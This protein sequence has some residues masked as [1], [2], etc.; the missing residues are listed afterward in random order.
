MNKH[1]VADFLRV[2]TKTVERYVKSG[3]LRTVYVG[4]KAV[5][6]K[7]EVEAFDME[8]KIPVHRAVPVPATDTDKPELSVSVAP[9]ATAVLMPVL[10]HLIHQLI[11]SE[12]NKHLYQRLTS[13][14]DEAVAMSGFSKKGITD[15]AKQGNL[16]G[17]KQGGS[18]KFRPGDVIKFV[19]SYF[20]GNFEVKN[21]RKFLPDRV[22]EQTA[23]WY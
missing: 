1:E 18:W 11:K 12:Q 9:E 6:D 13:N 21:G 14:L 23:K 17:V 2:T 15:A 8:A 19:D 16:V 10:S 3:K 22:P 4:G 7:E 20:D 5:F